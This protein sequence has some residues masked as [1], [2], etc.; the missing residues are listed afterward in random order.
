MVAVN[1]TLNCD[2]AWSLKAQA[3]LVPAYSHYDQTNVI[4]NLNFL[5]HL[6]PEN[7]L[8][9]LHRE[10]DDRAE[11]LLSILRSRVR[12]LDLLEP[13]RGSTGDPDLN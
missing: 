10:L 6:P 9:L 4:P 1:M 7:K 11:R 3:N 13:F 12:T 8:D 5:A 2:F